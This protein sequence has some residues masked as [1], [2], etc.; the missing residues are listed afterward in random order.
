[1]KLY[2]L[3][4][5]ER[6]DD[7]SFFSPLTKKGLTNANN[8]V[9]KLDKCNIDLIF[10]SPFIRTLQTIYPYAK[11]K[12][13]VI[14][15]DYSLSEIHHSDIIPKKSV[16]FKIPPD[17]ASDFNYNQ[18]YTSIINPNEII[19]PEEYSNIT[20]RMKKF[21]KFIYLKYK[22]TS[23][24]IILVTHQSLCKCALKINK[25]INNDELI[26]NYPTGKC[27]LILDAD[28]WIFKEL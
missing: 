4:H 22:D 23:Y 15:I 14:N 25:N 24:N 6:Y 10:C 20:K 2:I 26:K 5:E 13:L 27:C 7:C 12:K 1:M 17:I 3:R 18:N 9:N 16:G 11:K 19:Y 21:I 28:K 8:L